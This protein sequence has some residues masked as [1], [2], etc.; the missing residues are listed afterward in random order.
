MCWAVR[1]HCVLAYDD[2]LRRLPALSP[3][4]SKWRATA[5]HVTLDGEPVGAGHLP[6]AVRRAGHQRAAQLHAARAPGHAVDPGGF[7]PRRRCPTTTGRRRI[8]SLAANAFAQAEALLRGKI[9]GARCGPRWRAKGASP[10]EI[11]AVAPH[12]VCVRRAAVATPSCSAGWTRFTLGRLIALYEH[13]VAVQGCIWGIDS[14]DQ[15]GVELGKVLAGGILPE[16]TPGA[17]PGAHDAST[18][19]LI[20]RFR[21]LR[22]ET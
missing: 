21:T 15:W 1:T 10:A 18:T 13:K 22:G 4:G 7:H 17:A 3:A 2:R 11:D 9:G 5:S 14:F 16:L 20:A 8:A 12:R 6:G 19:G